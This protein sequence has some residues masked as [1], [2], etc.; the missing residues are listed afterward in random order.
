[1]DIGSKPTAG[2]VATPGTPAPSQGLPA[3]PAPVGPAPAGA[4]PPSPESDLRS[5]E[6][7]QPPAAARDDAP[8][9]IR[10]GLRHACGSRS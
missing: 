3:V 7:A 2:A 5:N 9:H 1:M 10:S 4:G 6:A 8:G